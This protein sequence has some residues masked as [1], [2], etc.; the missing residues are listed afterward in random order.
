[1]PPWGGEQVDDNK[2]RLTQCFLQVEADD[3]SYGIGGSIW[4]DAARLILT[5]L[6]PIVMGEDPLAT[7]PLW[8]QMHWFSSSRIRSCHSIDRRDVS[9][10][11]RLAG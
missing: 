7:E 3:G 2:L 6:R 9:Q 4:S 5:Q 8:D 11:V 10:S 1:M